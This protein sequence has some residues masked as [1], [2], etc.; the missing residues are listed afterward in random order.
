MIPEWDEALRA[1]GYVDQRSGKRGSWRGLSH[2]IGVHVTTLT[3]MARGER[4]TD[5]AIV[6]KVADA[7]GVDQLTIAEW[8]GRERTE[9]RPFQ[10][11]DG[12][13][14]M[15][16]DEQAAINSLITLLVRD[17]KRG[18]RDGRRPEAEKSASRGN[19]DLLK[20]ERVPHTASSGKS[21]GVVNGTEG[22]TAMVDPG[23]PGMDDPTAHDGVGRDLRSH[24][25]TRPRE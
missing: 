10:P 17:R 1:A 3:S 21:D 18:Q 20:S 7:L 8:I 11:V 13:D 5:Q 15:T 25:E 22:D 24:S 16:K 6:N 12:A 23:S 4:E 19:P 9:R 14:L 2:E